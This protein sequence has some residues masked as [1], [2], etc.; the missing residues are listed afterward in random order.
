[1][2]GN[3]FSCA[4]A[5]GIEATFSSGHVFANNLLDNC[6]YGIWAG[7]SHDSRFTAN[8]IRRS[9]TAAIAIEHGQDN[10][11]DRNTIEG[12][13]VGIKLRMNAKQDPNWPY[14]K[15]RDTRSRDYRIEFNRFNAVVPA[16]SIRDTANVAV[17]SDEKL[18]EGA[19]RAEG[20]C[21]GLKI[22][23]RKPNGSTELK[24]PERLPDGMDTA[25]PADYPRGRKY[26][27]IDDWGPRPPQ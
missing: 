17:T 2:Y 5:N 14:P 27:V 19:I 15:K 13:P 21:D 20:R 11:I 22:E 1:V 24:A 3:D 25:F 4:V 8:T 7:Y 12:G 26:I 10:L 16:I 23:V 18:P 9:L 6:T